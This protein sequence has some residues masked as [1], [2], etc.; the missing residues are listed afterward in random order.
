[1]SVSPTI[2]T[3]S[4]AIMDPSS[5]PLFSDIVSVRG[6]EME[7]VL[8]VHSCYFKFLRYCGKVISLPLSKQS[9]AA[10]GNLQKYIFTKYC[11]ITEQKVLTRFKCFNTELDTE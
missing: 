9:V 8:V 3:G 11:R 4:K 2:D 7:G 10:C 1:M 5:V 6:W